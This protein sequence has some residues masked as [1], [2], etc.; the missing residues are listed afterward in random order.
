MTAAAFSIV[1]PFGQTVGGVYGAGGEQRNRG[2]ELGAFGEVTPA[3]RLLG[4]LMFLDAELTKTD[5][6]TTKG[7]RPV[8]TPDIQANLT[9]EWDTP[10]LRGLTLNATVTHTSSQYVN[11]ANTQSI[12]EWTTLDLGAKYRTDVGNTPMTVRAIVQNVTNEAYW[13]SVNSWS[14]VSLGAPRTFLLST[15]FDF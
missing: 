2:L 3:I 7:N 1:K 6:A 4:G 11:T 8:G 13:S 15:S 12:P 5:S 9:A 10:F 14:M